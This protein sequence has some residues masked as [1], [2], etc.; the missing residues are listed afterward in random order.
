MGWDFGIGFMKYGDRW[1]SHRKLL[2]EAFNVTAIKQF[3]P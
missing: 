2:H 3:R 1:R